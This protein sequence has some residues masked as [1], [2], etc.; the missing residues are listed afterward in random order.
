[1]SAEVFN[2]YPFDVQI[3]KGDG[4]APVLGTIR[5]MTAVGFQ[6]DVP[7]S[8]CQIGFTYT[9][10]FE[11][12]TSRL[13]FNEKVMLVKMYHQYDAKVSNREGPI[14]VGEVKGEDKRKHLVEFHFRSLEAEKEIVLRA[15]EKKNKPLPTGKHG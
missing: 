2:H 7:L 4:G 10:D 1:M 14:M 11:I 8:V 9:A 12:E 13:P 5:R 15:F 6:A 3:S